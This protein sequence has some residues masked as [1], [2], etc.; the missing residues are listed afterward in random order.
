MPRQEDYSA[1]FYSTK[2]KQGGHRRILP[3]VTLLLL[4]LEKS[5]KSTEHENIL[6]DIAACSKFPLAF[7]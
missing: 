5:Y 2:L 4:D 1:V 7:L 6:R 3:W